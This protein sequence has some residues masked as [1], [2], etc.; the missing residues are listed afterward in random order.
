[1]NWLKS[2]ALSITIVIVVAMVIILSYFLG[3]IHHLLGI[4]SCLIVI[5]V[6]MAC[7]FK[8]VIFNKKRRE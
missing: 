7:L 5:M 8:F 6:I 3:D 4:G 1:M 2:V